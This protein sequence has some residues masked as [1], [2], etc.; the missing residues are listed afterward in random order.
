MVR[1]RSQKRER[2][3]RHP[4]TGHPNLARSL[5]GHNL[6]DAV[7]SRR[8][9]HTATTLSTTEVAHWLGADESTDD[10]GKRSQTQEQPILGP[11]RHPFLPRHVAPCETASTTPL[12]RKQA[13]HQ[14]RSF[15]LAKL[16]ERTQRAKH[17]LPA[18][19]FV[20]ACVAAVRT[21]SPAVCGRGITGGEGA[22]ACAGYPCG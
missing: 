18:H 12:R 13:I 15:S 16:L 7:D 22:R 19:G 8:C 4:V 17:S 14:H 2:V 3:T 10:G 20:S 6:D 11:S 9:C 1:H 21:Q 5:C